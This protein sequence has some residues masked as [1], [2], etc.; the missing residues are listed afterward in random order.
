MNDKKTIGLTPAGE[1]AMEQLMA[2]GCFKDMIDAAKFAMAIAIREGDAPLP[3]EG[4]NTIWNVGSFDSDGQIKQILPVLFAGCDSSYRAAESLIDQGLFR[5]GQIIA[6]GPFEPVRLLASV[7]ITV[8]DGGTS[9]LKFPD[10]G[11]NS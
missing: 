11:T 1:T 2:Q 3:V 9:T 10:G 5:I 4:A 7:S 8:A 6:I